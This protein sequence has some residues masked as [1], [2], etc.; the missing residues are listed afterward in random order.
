MTCFET[1]HS[2]RS[3]SAGYL[4][5]PIDHG[6]D[7]V[8]HSATKWIGGH[9]TTIAGVIIDSGTHFSASFASPAL[10]MLTSVFPAIRTGKSRKI[11][12]D[13][14]WKVPRL[15]RTFR[16]LPWSQVQRDLWIGGVLCQSA[17]RSAPRPGVCP[18]PVRSLP[19]P[20]RPRDS[21]PPRTE[22]F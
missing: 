21:Q 22:A 13:S 8:V 11:R 16:R 15:H 14:V 6:A 9:G 4:V 2:S 1:V 19:A 18:Q 10:H 3:T 5:R 17:R 20:P 7:I 12:L